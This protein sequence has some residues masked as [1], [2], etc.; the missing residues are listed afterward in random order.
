MTLAALT[1]SHLEGNLDQLLT[2]LPV[3]DRQREVVLCN[4][5]VPESRMQLT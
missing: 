1:V 5:S 2:V 4:L 3:S